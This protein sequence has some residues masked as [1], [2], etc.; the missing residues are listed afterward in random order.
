LVGWLVGGASASRSG[1][2]SNARA[3]VENGLLLTQIVVLSLG[4]LT[5]A[6]GVVFALL[7]AVMSAKAR[8]LKTEAG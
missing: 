3:T 5:V 4:G 2:A 7:C 6:V 8:R 1:L